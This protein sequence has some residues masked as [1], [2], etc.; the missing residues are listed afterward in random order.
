MKIIVEAQGSVD[1]QIYQ[2]QFI[3][4]EDCFFMKTNMKVRDMSIGE[5]Q[6]IMKQG[7]SGEIRAN[8][9]IFNI[10]KKKENVVSTTRL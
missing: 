3:T 5:K 6:H 9:T 1:I 7:K 4:Y 10:L 2:I 8:A